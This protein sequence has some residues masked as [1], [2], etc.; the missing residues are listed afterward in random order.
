[1]KKNWNDNQGIVY[2][3]VLRAYNSEIEL[4]L[5]KKWH[6]IR[7]ALICKR[8][9]F[10]VGKVEFGQWNI[11]FK[12]CP[13]TFLFNSAFWNE[14]FCDRPIVW[15]DENVDNIFE[16]I[17]ERNLKF[18]QWNDIRN[19]N[20]DGYIFLNAFYSNWTDSSEHCHD[21]TLREK[22]MF[23]VTLIHGSMSQVTLLFLW[24]ND[25]II[26]NEINVKKKIKRSN[27]FIL[28]TSKSISIK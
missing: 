18:K 28:F 2:V 22:C 25:K 1:M 5:F 24:W 26:G 7:Y 20:I 15:S 8:L 27:A 19:K 17:R 6:L 13:K 12:R 14:C 3:C 23:K 9:R 11:F 21:A 16:L 4:L 10:A